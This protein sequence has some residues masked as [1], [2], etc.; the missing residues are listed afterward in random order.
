MD[1]PISRV[2]KALEENWRVHSSSNGLVSPVVCSRNNRGS[3]SSFNA[4]HWTPTVKTIRKSGNQ[5][6]SLTV[7][8]Y[9]SNGVSRW[10]LYS[11][12]PFPFS[13]LFFL[14]FLPFSSFCFSV[15]YPIFSQSRDAPLVLTPHTIQLFWRSRDVKNTPADCK[16]HQKPNALFRI[17]TKWLSTVHFE[18]LYLGSHALG[19]K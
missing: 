17:S 14:L 3:N 15:F 2:W 19:Q 5:C 13:L 4:R 10:L 6:S 7:R 16:R 8:K 12:L 1:R 11:N 9:Q 18:V